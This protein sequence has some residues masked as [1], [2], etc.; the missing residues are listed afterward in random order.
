MGHVIT[1]YGS[2]G[3]KVA[4]VAVNHSLVGSIPTAT[5]LSRG[6]STSSKH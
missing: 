1:K 2:E 4:Q 6:T 5:T 3:A